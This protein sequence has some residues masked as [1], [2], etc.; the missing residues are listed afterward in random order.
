[1]SIKII[2]ISIIHFK[3]LKIN[4]E[5]KTLKNNSSLTKKKR[6]N[7]SY[8]VFCLKCLKKF[9]FKLRKYRKSSVT[10]L[11]VKNYFSQNLNFKN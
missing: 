6:L 9:A 1:M 8:V 11:S 2:I 3:N 5:K 10:F 4:I 7:T